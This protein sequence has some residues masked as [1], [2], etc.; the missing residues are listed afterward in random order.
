VK[1]LRTVLDGMT[2]ENAPKEFVRTF[3]DGFAENFDHQLQQRLSYKIPSLLADRFRALPEMK[4]KSRLSLLDLG[5]GTGLVAE[6][7]KDITGLRVGVDL[8]DLMLQKARDKQLYAELHMQDIVEFMLAC[9]RTFDLAIA[10]DVLIYVGN[11]VPFF[12]ASRNVLSAS[13]LLAF[14]IEIEESTD[15][16]PLNYATG[17]YSH[18]VP[19]ILSLAQKEEYEVVLQEECVLRTEKG[20]PVKGLLL[21]LKKA[22]IH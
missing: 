14:S 12:N 22:Q 11:P 4:N 16:F 13:G 9:K 15:P 21:I 17:R 7:L 2:I 19:Y 18:N 3:F 5:C 1:H 20:Q 8:S 10:T 6:A